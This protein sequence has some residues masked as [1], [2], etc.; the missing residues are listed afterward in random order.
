MAG[1]FW[2]TRFQAPAPMCPFPFRSSDFDEPT[3]LPGSHAH[4][5]SFLS[6]KGDKCGQFWQVSNP[7]Q[8]LPVPWAHA[9]FWTACGLRVKS[10]PSYPRPVHPKLS[11]QYYKFQ[12]VRAGRYPASAGTWSHRP[13]K[14]LT[15]SCLHC[16]CVSVL[17]YGGSSLAPVSQVPAEGRHPLFSR[18]PAAASKFHPAHRTLLL[19]NWKRNRRRE[20]IVLNSWLK[21]LWSFSTLHTFS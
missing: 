7:W 12:T 1:I 18:P 14:S 20:H 15:L 13:R 21:K 6:Y 8:Q 2:E 4:T 19:T 11:T 17:V 10:L 5:L 9:E 3:D 16:G